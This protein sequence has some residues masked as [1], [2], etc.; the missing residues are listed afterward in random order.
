VGLLEHPNG[1]HRDTAARLL[2]ERRDAAVVPQLKH[3]IRAAKD[4]HGRL[5]ALYACDGLSS[6]DVDSVLAALTD[7]SP[8]VREHAVL[9]AEPRLAQ[10]PALRAAIARLADDPSKRVRFQVAFTLGEVGGEE[11]LRGLVAIARHDAEDLWVRT[12]VLSSAT[13]DPGRLFSRLWQDRGFAASAAGIA[14]MRP[15]ALVVGARNRPGEAAR[16]LAAVGAVG[17]GDAEAGRA[18]TLGLGDGLARAGRRLSDLKAELSPAAAAWLDRQLA[19]AEVLAADH[20]RIPGRRAEAVALLGHGSFERAKGIIRGLL[21]PLEPPE[22]QTAAVRVIA[23]FDRPEVPS[24]LLAPWKVYSPAL[25]AEVVGLLLGRRTWIASVLDAVGAGL[26]PAG[27]IPPNR[28]SLLLQDRDAAIRDRARALLAGI[29]PG[30]RAAAIDRYKSAIAR[31]GDPDRGQ[32]L[33]D[34]HCL[35]C[36]KLGERGHAVG[37]NLASMRRKTPEEILVSILDPNREVSPEFIE[38]LVALDDG[39]VVT[40]LVASE[41]PGGLALRGREGAEQTVLRRNIAEIAAT[42]KSLMPEGLENT[43]TPPEMTDLISFL[44]KIQD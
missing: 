31:A 9:L 44:L 25:R 3:L 30:P 5:H 33:F 35:A 24:I 28:R 16:I 27:E 29:A 6:L 14:L 34:R 11:S 23:D 21:V 43:I 41:T 40:G 37:P 36:H 26:V 15:L 19:E 20:S 22:I 42:G 1:W 4:P 18:V 8:S 13:A 38:Y 17:A 12:A 32:L 39:R 10:S 2:V 7:A